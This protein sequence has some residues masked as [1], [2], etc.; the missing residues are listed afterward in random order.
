MRVRGSIDVKEVF[1]NHQAAAAT[2][3]ENANAEPIPVCQ[4]PVQL[5]TNSY[6]LD[7]D[8]FDNG[9]SREKITT[10]RLHR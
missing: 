7:E 10:G 1:L 3:P 9:L 8:Q 6:F 5:D 4:L 2:A